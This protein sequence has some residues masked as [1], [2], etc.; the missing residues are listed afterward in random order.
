MKMH[1]FFK[2]VLLYFQAYIRQTKYNS[3]DNQLKM[4]HF[5]PSSSLL[6][7]MEQTN[8]YK[9]IVMMAKEG[10]TKIVIF[11]M[12]LTG[13]LVLEWKGGGRVEDG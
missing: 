4:Q 6:W 11:T 12:I 8:Y 1:Y 7:G 3:N 13:I 5:F 10:S 9:Y 2:N